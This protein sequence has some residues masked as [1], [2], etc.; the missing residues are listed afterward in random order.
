MGLP[1]VSSHSGR[2]LQI[3]LPTVF[4]IFNVE[5]HFVIPGYLRSTLA[6]LAIS[7]TVDES[8][9]SEPAGLAEQRKEPK[10]ERDTP[11]YSLKREVN[12]PANT[13]RRK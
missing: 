7:E 5:F 10:G 3:G 9:Q 6:E 12:I 11:C 8:E 4:H 13:S 1:I 2:P